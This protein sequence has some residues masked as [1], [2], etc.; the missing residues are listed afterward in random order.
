MAKNKNNK[1]KTFEK[2]TNKQ[3]KLTNIENSLEGNSTNINAQHNA[4][5]EALGPN[6]NQ[7][8]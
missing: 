4:K 3:Q 1:N 6:I 7:L 8:R 2:P 5:K